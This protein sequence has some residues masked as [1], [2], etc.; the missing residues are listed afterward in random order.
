VR[1]LQDFACARTDQAAVLG[2]VFDL[3]LIAEQ[4]VELLK[5]YWKTNPEKRGIKI[6][7]H[8]D[9]SPGCLVRGKEDEMVEVVVNLLKNAVEALPAGGEINISTHVDDNHVVLKVRDNGVGIDQSNLERIFE[10]FWSTKGV[11]GIGMGLASSYGIIRRHKG[12]ILAKSAPGKGTVFTVRLPLE[13][14]SSESRQDAKVHRAALACRVLVI[15]DSED[16]VWVLRNGLTRGGQEVLAALSGR[17]GIDIF[18]NERVDAVICDLGMPEINGLEVAKI[19]KKI[20]LER[21]IAKPPFILLTGWGG[22]LDEKEKLWECG[23]D[24]VVEKPFLI[25]NLMEIVHDL[26]EERP[27]R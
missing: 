10:P 8:R 2:Q 26:L 15:D 11:D 13:E 24:R 4:T 7:L 21:G 14:K 23:V 6:F 27:T 22:L 9:V 1:R 5:P 12:E 19:L 25:H 18:E 20:C 16:S 3:S 17:Q